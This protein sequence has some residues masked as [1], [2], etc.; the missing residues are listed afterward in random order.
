MMDHVKALEKEVAAL[1]GK[2]A[3][4]Q[5]DEMLSQAVDI[6][7]VKLLVA[8]LDGAD[9]KTLR[10]TMDKLKDKLKTAVIVLGRGGWRQGADRR[11]RDHRHHGQGQGR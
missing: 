1:K 3:S 4:A 2:L 5:G 10:E 11:G 9:V 7:G 8:K 6:N